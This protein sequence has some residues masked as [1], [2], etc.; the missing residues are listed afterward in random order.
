[1][2]K[3]SVSSLLYPGQKIKSGVR[4]TVFSLYVLFSVTTI[5][6]I[7]ET[8][9]KLNLDYGIQ[10]ALKILPTIASIT[11]TAYF[12]FFDLYDYIKLRKIYYSESKQRLFV[13]RRIEL[14]KSIDFMCKYWLEGD[15]CPLYICERSPRAG[16]TEFLKKLESVLKN[17]RRSS[18]SRLCEECGISDINKV[19]LFKKLKK[20]IG[21]VFLIENG[22]FASTIDNLPSGKANKINVLLVDEPSAY[23]QHR[24]VVAKGYFFVYI[25]PY[26][27]CLSYLSAPDAVTLDTFS[28]K[29]VQDYMFAKGI[30]ISDTEA[31]II[32]QI[33]DGNIN[34][35][36]INLD[37]SPMYF[38][39]IAF[40]RHDYVCAITS[41]LQKILSQMSVGMYEK[42]EKDLDE[43]FARHE[44]LICNNNKLF[45]DWTMAKAQVVHLL[46][47][48]SEALAELT[49]IQGAEFGPFHDYPDNTIASRRCHYV[50]HTGD[51]DFAIAIANYLPDYKSLSLNILAYISKLFDCASAKSLSSALGGDVAKYADRLDVLLKS[52]GGATR[53]ASYEYYSRYCDV[54]RYL[55]AAHNNPEEI[56]SLT[57]TD[58]D[59]K[60]ALA[61]S[62]STNSRLQ[63][64]D[65]FII[66]EL[67]R[68]N[69]LKDA[70][71]SP[72]NKKALLLALSIRYD[73]LRSEALKNHDY[74]L[75]SQTECMLFYLNRVQGIK[76]IDINIVDTKTQCLQK[77]MNFNAKLCSGLIEIVN[78]TANKNYY[79]ELFNEIP[80]VIL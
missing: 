73:N 18:F 9:D 15:N 50:K 47:R 38:D 64:N 55:I 20:K 43:L 60:S 11:S 66:C 24:N 12:A 29:D 25:K 44:T 51:F 27:D 4:L 69:L 28:A 21:Y 42:S 6:L 40:V 13:G 5:I 33:T 77:G 45:F 26:P 30:N 35:L 7:W 49:K 34:K 58:S 8:V 16:E 57:A 53:G 22:N 59:I 61:I 10:L 14:R 68:I 56:H 1:M 70:T 65:Q 39:L 19:D 78:E 71:L 72:S 41:A 2:D 17:K 74:N 23:K 31:N 62:L 48:Y 63:L 46:N 3:R 67:E 52:I 80:F 37:A 76:T 36:Q 79:I 54:A 75:Q 32:V